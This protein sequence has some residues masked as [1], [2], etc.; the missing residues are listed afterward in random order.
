MASKRAII[1]HK[2]GAARART[3]A[4]R[5]SAAT[6]ME[7]RPSTER[8]IWKMCPVHGVLERVRRVD[9]PPLPPKAFEPTY[10]PHTGRVHWLLKEGYL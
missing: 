8:V 6:R 3:E 4:K 1:R 10:S 9:L 5:A 2:K 7:K